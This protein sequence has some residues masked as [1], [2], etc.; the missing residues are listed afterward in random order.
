MRPA[1]TLFSVATQKE[2]FTTLSLRI[3]VEL[4]EKYS[5]TSYSTPHWNSDTGDLESGLGIRILTKLDG[6]SDA[7][8]G[9]GTMKL[10]ICY[11]N[12]TVSKER[13]PDR[14][15]FSQSVRIKRDLKGHLAKCHIV[16]YPLQHLDDYL[17]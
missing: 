16:F 9:N 2:W 3:T 8:L 10:G 4:L 17:K 13:K 7:K 12:A 5:H 14:R 15:F 11:I 1:W 6:A